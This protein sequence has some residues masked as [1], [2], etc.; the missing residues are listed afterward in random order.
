MTI[1]RMAMKTLTIPKLRA[2][3]LLTKFFS[4]KI[5]EIDFI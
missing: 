4:L 3:L 1:L 5:N 2:Y